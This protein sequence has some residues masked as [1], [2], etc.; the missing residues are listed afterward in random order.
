MWTV[1]AWIVALLAFVL[2]AD[3]KVRLLIRESEYRHKCDDCPI[4]IAHQASR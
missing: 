2:Y 4:R 3:A 1:I